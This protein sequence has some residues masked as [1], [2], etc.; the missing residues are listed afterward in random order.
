MIEIQDY[1][2]RGEKDSTYKAIEEKMA[3]VWET[4]KS[5]YKLEQGGY[6]QMNLNKNLYVS[7]T[8]SYDSPISYWMASK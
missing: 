8:I 6:I 1:L 2:L 7:K 3:K 5:K 4:L